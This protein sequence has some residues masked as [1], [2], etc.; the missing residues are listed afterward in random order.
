MEEEI[1]SLNAPD[2]ILKDGC[3]IQRVF[4]VSPYFIVR[5]SIN[6]DLPIKLSLIKLLLH[7][8]IMP[9]ISPFVA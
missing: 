5:K 2:Y 9:V 4:L 6:C 7:A 1:V 3:K 8:A